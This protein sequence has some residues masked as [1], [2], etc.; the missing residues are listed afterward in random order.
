MKKNRILS[1][2]LIAPL[3]LSSCSDE[4]AIHDIYNY[5][6][7][8]KESYY[9]DVKATE[10]I[11]LIDSGN[12]M[13]IFIYSEGCSHC[14]EA[15]PV[16]E[17]VLEKYPHS[18]YRYEFGSDYQYLI[19][20]NEDIFS[21]YVTTP[22]LF[23][24]K[25]KR[26]YTTIDASRLMYKTSFKSSI[27]KYATFSSMYYVSLLES[28][29]LFKQDVSSDFILFTYDSSSLDSCSLYKQVFDIVTNYETPTLFVDTNKCEDPLLEQLEIEGVEV[30]GNTLCYITADGVKENLEQVTAQGITTFLENYH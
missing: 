23:T 16:M 9:I 10:L 24:V 26:L 30:K 3:L 20:Y 7:A 5:D 27:N 8:S 25:D 14:H 21:N 17:E 1:L 19:D 13:T 18:L 15:M 22:A 2:I 29:T 12:Q 6:I 11:N 28:Y 4:Q